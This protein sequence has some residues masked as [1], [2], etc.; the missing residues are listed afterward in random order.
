MYFIGLGLG[1]EKDVTIK[2]MDAIKR[3]SR[4]YLEAYTSVLGGQLNKERLVSCSGVLLVAVGW[5]R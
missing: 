3:S 4:V 2:G 5:Q 1:D